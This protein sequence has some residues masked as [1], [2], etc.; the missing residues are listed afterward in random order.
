M[1][2]V[3]T[4]D[5]GVHPSH[6]SRHR[7]RRAPNLGDYNTHTEYASTSAFGVSL[8]TQTPACSPLSMCD[9]A[10]QAAAVTV[11]WC[12]AAAMED[13]VGHFGRRAASGRRDEDFGARP[14]AVVVAIWSH[15]QPLYQP[16]APAYLQHVLDSARISKGAY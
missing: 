6:R 1:S 5:Y 15:G 9:A 2:G 8:S 14:A 12:L 7:R 13:M 3:E 10:P 11:C 16:L 4:S